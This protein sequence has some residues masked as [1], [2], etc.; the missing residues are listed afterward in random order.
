M[1]KLNYMAIYK[2]HK[3]EN[4]DICHLILVYYYNIIY[5]DLVLINNIIYNNMSLKPVSDNMEYNMKLLL[6]QVCKL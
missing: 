3:D 2:F 5:I 1:A 6:L 4:M